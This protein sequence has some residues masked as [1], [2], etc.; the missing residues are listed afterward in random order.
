MSLQKYLLDLYQFNLSLDKLL[1]D[2]ILKNEGKIIA[3]V[4]NRLYQFG[5]DGDGNEITPTY[6]GSTIR[7]KKEKNQRTSHVT[8]RDSG[9]FYKGFYLELVGYDLILHSSDNKSSALLDKYGAA[10]LHFTKQEKDFI[11]NEIIDP[12]IEAKIK[13]LGSNSSSATGLDVDFF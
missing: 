3:L 1:K 10:I 4:K 5:V 11:L 12:A 2:I 8:L 9:L 13:S 7:Y 6:S